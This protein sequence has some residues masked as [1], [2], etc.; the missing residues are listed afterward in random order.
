L[1]EEWSYDLIE[2]EQWSHVHTQQLNEMPG[3][4]PLLLHICKR[5]PQQTHELLKWSL[6]AAHF[7]H[8]QLQAVKLVTH[9]HYVDTFWIAAD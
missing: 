9:L 1:F 6:I 3:A 7:P 8:N 4:W 5:M 2:L